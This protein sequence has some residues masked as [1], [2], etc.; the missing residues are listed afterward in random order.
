MVTR[1]VTKEN[2]LRPHNPEIKGLN[3][4][5]PGSHW[6]GRSFRGA[7]WGLAFGG[8]CRSTMCWDTTDMIVVGAIES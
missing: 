8:A 7:S 4:P 3:D 6:D 2:D 1:L 5:C